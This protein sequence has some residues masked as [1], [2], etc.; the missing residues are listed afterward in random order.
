[1]NVAVIKFPHWKKAPPEI[2]D[3]NNNCGPLS[4]WQALEV[5]GLQVDPVTILRLT[6]F[7]PENGVLSIVLALGFHELGLR[8]EF[9]SEGVCSVDKKFLLEATEKNLPILPPA[10]LST[11]LALP[12]LT[13]IA[14]DTF[15]NAGHVSPISKL[16]ENSVLVS[17]EEIPVQAI[18][19]LEERR[20]HSLKESISI[21]PR[22]ADHRLRG[23]MNRGNPC[24]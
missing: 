19:T 10:D 14:Y 13:I 22:L 24:D 17:L 16:T 2:R 21:Y 11:L 8:T 5:L 20:R 6:R 18:G 1:M 4:M 23:G 9:R 12:A 7:S 15:D 3:L